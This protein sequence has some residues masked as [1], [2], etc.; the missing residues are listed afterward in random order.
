M[1]VLLEEDGELCKLGG[2]RSQRRS[3]EAEGEV[4]GGW[5]EVRGGRG[6]GRVEGGQGRP[7]T[8]RAGN[9]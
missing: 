9:E 2:L 3:G 7:R 5:R 4:R 8:R 1:L 6:Q